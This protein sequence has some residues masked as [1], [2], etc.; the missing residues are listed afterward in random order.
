VYFA[1]D[2]LQRAGNRHA[3]GHRETD[4]V[5]EARVGVGILSQNDDPHAVERAEVEDA[6]EIAVDGTDAQRAVLLAHERRQPREIGFVE[7]FLQLRTPALFD[8]DLHGAVV[9][10]AKVT[11][12]RPELQRLFA[13]LAGCGMVSGDS[14]GV[15]QPAEGS[16]GEPPLQVAVRA[17]HGAAERGG[18]FPVG[19][20]FVRRSPATNFRL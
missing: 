14:I 10:Y 2:V 15:S 13:L 19:N 18:R 4:S 11:V 7:L 1:E 8:L 6:E 12:F 3:V 9:F 17:V 5:V 16:H 20:L